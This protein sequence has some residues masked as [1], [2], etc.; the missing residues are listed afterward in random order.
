M[1][2]LLF[3][4][5][6]FA[7]ATGAG[8]TLL[9]QI[10][11]KHIV[12]NAERFLIAFCLGCL[13]LYY[14]VFFVG[15]IR[16]DHQSMLIV[17]GLTSLIAAPSLIH[18]ARNFDR[19]PAEFNQ[20]RQFVERERFASLLWALVIAILILAFLEG[21]APPNDTDSMTYHL[22]VPQFNLEHG[23]IAPNW[24]LQGPD[25]YPQFCENLYRIAIAVSG[26]QAA[27][28]VSGLFG[29]MMA[30]ST[31]LVAYRL[32]FGPTVAALSALMAIGL[33]VIVWELSTCYVEPAIAT[34]TALCFLVLLLWRGGGGLPT[35]V[36]FGL[37]AGSGTLVKYHGLAL[38][39]CFALVL[40]WDGLKGRVRWSHLLV[41]GLVAVLTMAPH[42]LRNIY[43]TGNPLFPFYNP[44]FHPGGPDFFNMSSVM[45]RSRLVLDFFRMPWDISIFSTYFYDGMQLGAPYLLAFLPFA[46]LIR[47]RPIAP[48]VCIT[49]AYSVCWFWMLSQQIRFLLPIMP[50]VAV[51]CAGGAA[52]AWGRS[53]TWAKYAIAAVSAILVLNQSLFIGAYAMTR[54]PPVL[55]RMD[56]LTYLS[57]TPGL[58]ATNYGACTFVKERLAPNDKVL[59]MTDAPSL[60]C[61]QA[62][63]IISPSMPE[64]QDWWL[65][66][67][68][69]P[70]LT[71]Q[72]LALALSSH[73]IKYLFVTEH[74]EMRAG[75]NSKPTTTDVDY[76]SDRIAILLQPVL[77]KTQPVYRDSFAAVYDA[78][79]LISGL[80]PN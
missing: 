56:T 12:P 65:T 37:L 77:A 14:G 38:G 31:A 63:S 60:Y 75:P 1:S 32:G 18:A 72:S 64:E 35:A 33:R 13:L 15:L 55:G 45:G 66:K 34:F 6:L 44:I 41:A 48:M 29:P 4:A 5:C 74:S 69:L 80:Q 51:L 68:P 11:K 53:Q 78:Q 57:T 26:I 21:L 50:F 23:F 42:G 47:R 3:A 61:P 70:T 52:V 59:I 39:L 19:I 43:Y 7:I 71:S 16:F 73:S 79:T 54:L 49:L 22:S 25:F 24:Y 40:V 67:R 9:G 28:P 17:L 58:G 30:A 62:Q 76:S 27:Q 2:S 8:W 36:L 46:A 20:V 10:D